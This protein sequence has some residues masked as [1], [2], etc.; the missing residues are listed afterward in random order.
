MRG[1]TWWVIL[2]RVVGVKLAIA[3]ALTLR[4][5]GRG[6]ANYWLLDA[7]HGIETGAFVAMSGIVVGRVTAKKQRGD[8]TFLR[9]GF[10]AKWDGLPRS[11]IL[12]LERVGVEGLVAV[13]LASG[14]DGPGKGVERGGQL[15][16]IFETPTTDPRDPRSSDATPSPFLWKP[17][18]SGS[19][20]S[21]RPPLR[22]T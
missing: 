8:T 20:A 16:V 1:R 6:P 12:M 14:E 11:R 18:P 21:L 3:L 10:T 22:S 4:D 2:V 17:I 9:I 5:G 15:R 13:E 7:A 19:P